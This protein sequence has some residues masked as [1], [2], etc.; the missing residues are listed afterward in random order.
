MDL[1]LDHPLRS[2]RSFNRRFRYHNPD[3]VEMLF[4]C[5]QGE[6]SIDTEITFERYLVRMRKRRGY[7]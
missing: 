5:A 2:M 6:F 7:D 1:L 4:L 3:V